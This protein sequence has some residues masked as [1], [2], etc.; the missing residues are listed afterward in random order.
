MAIIYK[1]FRSAEYADFLSVGETLGAPIDREDGYIHLS[2][3]D[4]VEV[5][6][7]KHFAGEDGLKLLGIES[8]DLGDALKWEP[9]RGGALFPHLYRP[10]RSDDISFVRDL[11]F[12]D[13]RHRFKGLLC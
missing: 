2:A 6:A 7:S 13:G 12:E 11:P 3:S 5:T 1:I 10:L 4:Q 9:S 8:N